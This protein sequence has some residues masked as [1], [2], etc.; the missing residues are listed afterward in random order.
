M[1][2]EAEAH[3]SGD[4]PIARIW[5]H[6]NFSIYMA[7]SV[8]CTITQWMQRVGVGWLAWELTESPVWLGAM[9]AAEMAPMLIMGPIAGALTDRWNP[10]T[11]LRI[12]QWLFVAQAFSLATA[13]YLGFASI[14]VLFFISLAYGL[15]LP[16]FSTARQSVLPVTVPRRHIS[17]AI[18][19]DSALFQLTRFIGPA[20]AAIAIPLVGV[21]GV[22]VVHTFGNIVFLI[23]VYAMNVPPPERHAGQREGL[24]REI[25]ASFVYVRAHAGIWPVFLL[26]TIASI[27]IRPVQDMLPGF[28]GDVFRSDAIGLAYLSSA[29]GVGAMVS[30]A[31]VA[32]RGR[33]SGLTGQAVM[34]ALGLSIST[35][36]FIVTDWLWFGVFFSAAIGFTLNSISTAISALVQ[37]AVSDAMRGRV[38]ALYVLIF[39]ATP[40]IGSVLI[41]LASTY[42]GLRWSFAICAAICFA[43]WLLVLPRR[44]DIA[45]SLEV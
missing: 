7:G 11:P 5:G 1:A 15:I 44:R 26:L 22:F 45:A 32:F 20:L 43:A 38:V 10:M 33:L 29:M 9:A 8:P 40:A 3:T 6:R 18:A 30:A 4:K 13:T 2:N 21:G 14:W 31:R 28:A 34:G 24:W 19:I 42:I 25:G 12:S 39:R 16:Q 37:T 27:F 35:L 17:T 23:A 36:G 41:G